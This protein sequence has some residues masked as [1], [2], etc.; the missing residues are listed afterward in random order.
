MRQLLSL[1]TR[2]HYRPCLLCMKYRMVHSTC[3]SHLEIDERSILK[4]LV[5]CS[6]Q[7]FHVQHP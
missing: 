1:A 6:I 3:T 7:Y 5:E 2:Q 4:Q